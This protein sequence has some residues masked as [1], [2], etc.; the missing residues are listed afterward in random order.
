M[1]STDIAVVGVGCR[2]PDAATPETFWRNLDTGLV[3]V[4][5]LDDDTL[6]AVGV[7][8]ATLRD[9]AFVRTA[10][11]L[12]DAPMFASEFFGYPPAEAEMIDPQQRLFLEAC[13]EAL[14]S[15]AHPA[16][17]DGP[18]IGV[19][20][21]GASSTY[22][23]AV[24]AAKVRDAGLAAAVDDMGLH[25]G[26][27]GDF[28]SSRVAYKLGLRGP[29]VGVQT[30]CSSSLYA[31]HYASLS[32]LAGECDLALAG[33]A[34]VLEPVMGYRYQPGGLMSEDGLCRAFDSRSTGTSFS[35]GVGVVVLRRLADAIADRDHILAVVRGSAVGN[36]G[37]RRSSFT[38]P[39]PS[40]V[41][42]V[43]SGALRVADASAR[44]LRY[45]EA[46]GSGTSLGD[47]IELRGLSEGLRRT[48]VGTGYCGLGSVK[49]N[50][51][52][53]GPAAGIAGFIKGVHVV[54]TG[55]LSPHP[56][57]ENPRNP[58]MLAESPFYLTSEAGHCTEDDRLVLVNS[59]GLGGTNAAAVLAPPPAERPAPVAGREVVTLTL[60]ARNRTELDSMSRNLADRLDRG[61]TA[62]ADVAHT[63]RVGRHDF[64]MRRTV[65]GP[66]ERL[67]GIL[68][69]PRAPAARTVTAPTRDVVVVLDG[70]VAADGPLVHRLRQAFGPDCEIV[71]AA[72]ARVS[73]DRFAI[74]IGPG[75][76]ADR[77]RRLRPDAGT[78]LIDDVIVEAWLHGVTV[79]WES[80][81]DGTGRRVP[82][83]TYPFSRRRHWILDRLNTSAPAVPQ[84]PAG[85]QAVAGPQ[86]GAAAAPAGADDVEQALTAIWRELFGVDTIGPD[87]EFGALGGTSLLSVQMALEVQHRLGVLVNVHRAGGSRAT[88]RRIAQIVRGMRGGAARGADDIDPIADGDGELVDL[89]IQIALGELDRDAR[90]TGTDV[91]L[92]GATGFLGTFLLNELLRTTKGR[93]YCI[94]RAPDEEQARS[95]LAAAATA[96][97]LPPPDLD[98]VHLV[99][100]DLTDAGTLCDGFRD[101]ELA[102]RVGT[103]VHCAAK[104]VFT[105]P[106]RVLRGDNV[107]TTVEL[108][109]WMRRHGLRD[110]SFVSTLAA[111]HHALGENGRILE[112]RDQPLDPQQG[113]YG[114]GK[115]V[116]ERILERA[117]ADGMRVRIFRPGFILGSTTTGACNDKDLVWHVAASGLAVGAHPLDDRAM[118]MAPVDVVARAVAELS[119]SP[120][121]AGRVY[122]LTDDVAV[123]PRRLFAMLAEAG[124]ATEEV[125]AQEWQRRVAERSL[126]T[127]NELL[128]TM[129]LYEL[130]GHALGERDL[131]AV[132][133]RP[134]LTERG[135]SATPDGEL[136]RRCL[137]YLAGSTAKFGDLISDVIAQRQDCEV[138]VS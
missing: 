28:L 87:H 107:L 12:P 56:L 118:P 8:D 122:H 99:L 135:L 23:S 75:E 134:W 45:V 94:V 108:V 49:V 96:L 44:D 82:L 26:G 78:A 34:T 7:T 30:A 127:G 58:G 92:T 35:S 83:P 14:E 17:P 73:E 98:R 21:G 69:I 112:T 133:W 71:D 59:M 120:A 63:L 115:W 42:D 129:A 27:L 4:R 29:A 51:G 137:A 53:P 54:R 126:S 37:S 22:S 66:A 1:S 16:R 67:A 18:V 65:A 130:E 109:R 13:W 76:D 70:E 86:A 31:V 39:S 138:E 90:P 48:A 64:D 84:P 36:D 123:S 19:F 15:A 95:R 3:S 132:A 41:S 79:N 125:P 105:E 111:T 103:V 20:A 119:M 100:G 61:D 85:P 131:E 117:E 77:L 91:L 40:G 9:P 106:Y 24:F 43:V 93:V 25:L 114:V 60:S 46:H 113:G 38:A 124:L 47:Q 89:D 101:G 81:A 74:R 32:L 116:C 62:P 136:L 68:R 33:G 55:N 57:F 52:H 88:V 6:R 121:S 5:P 110:L 104:V 102:R 11:T 2:F 128:A 72:P 10:A 80:L 97:T 50:V